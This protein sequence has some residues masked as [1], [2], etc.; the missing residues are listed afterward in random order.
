MLR[1]K[2]QRCGQEAMRL[3]AVGTPVSD[4][5][6]FPCYKCGGRVALLQELPNAR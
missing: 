2:C 4:V 3:Y 6:A 1:V 5:T